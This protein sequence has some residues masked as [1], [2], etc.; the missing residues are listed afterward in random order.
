MRKNTN[1]YDQR[2][3]FGRPDFSK[4]KESIEKLQYFK[5][6]K[7]NNKTNPIVKNIKLTE[8]HSYRMNFTWMNKDY[9]EKVWTGSDLTTGHWEWKHYGPINVKLDIVSPT[10]DKVNAYTDWHGSSLSSRANTVTF[11]FKPRES[12]I[13]K[14]NFYQDDKERKEIFD[15]AFTYSEI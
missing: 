4:I 5:F 11:E 8:G 6:S 10:D 7:N 1:T 9:A 2:I 13:Y 3:G 14:L 12:G 15:V